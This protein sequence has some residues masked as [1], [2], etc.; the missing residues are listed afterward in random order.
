MG[1]AVL[2]FH[3]EDNRHEQDLFG[4]SNGEFI[5]IKYI[6]YIISHEILQNCL[7]WQAEKFCKGY[8][9]EMHY[10]FHSFEDSCWRIALSKASCDFL[11]VSDNWNISSRKISVHPI[12]KTFWFLLHSKCTTGA[13]YLFSIYPPPPCPRSKINTVTSCIPQLGPDLN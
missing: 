4:K 8:K 6:S 2:Q 10:I 5:I 3:I 11:S 9:I 1:N 7:P 12:F 13:E